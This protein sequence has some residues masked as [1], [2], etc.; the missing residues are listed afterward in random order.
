MTIFVLNFDMDG[1]GNNRYKKQRH[2]IPEHLKKILK[3]SRYKKKVQ[4]SLIICI[5]FCSDMVYTARAESSGI[6]PFLLLYLL[7]SIALKAYKF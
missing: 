3:I 6:K 4:I 7:S 2:S 5:L 1:E